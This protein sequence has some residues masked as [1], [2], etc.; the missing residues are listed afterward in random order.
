MTTLT[1]DIPHV[2]TF[3]TTGEP[4]TN[5]G[6]RVSAEEVI[7]LFSEHT[8]NLPFEVMA[9]GYGDDED[10]VGLNFDDLNESSF[11]LDASYAELE[12]QW[13]PFELS[14]GPMREPTPEDIEAADARG[15][16]MK[17]WR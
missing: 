12:T 17:E 4:G 1:F 5:F 2:G 14:I 16:Y 10:W 15:Y 8:W 7:R 6:L 11:V 3:E 13:G 9:A